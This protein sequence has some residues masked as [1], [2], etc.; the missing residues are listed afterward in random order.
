MVLFWLYPL[1]PSTTIILSIL[2]SLFIVAVNTAPVPSPSTTTSGAEV[3]SLPLLRTIA[4][5]MLPL[6]IIALIWVFFPIE[7]PMIGFLSKS[8]ILVT[9]YPTPPL[10][11]WT[12]S[13][14]P[15]NFGWSFATNSGP[16][17][18]LPVRVTSIGGWLKIWVPIPELDI[19]TYSFL[20]ANIST[21]LPTPTSDN[22]N[23]SLSKTVAI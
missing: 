9:P 23:V 17:A 11:I 4:S 19:L 5:V 1:P 12:L 16:I 18:V 21:V 7:Y 15:K 20:L 10:E 13:T 2:P 3:K 14:E 8:W 22:V 6:L